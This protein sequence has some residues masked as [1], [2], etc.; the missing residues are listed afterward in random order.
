MEPKYL[1]LEQIYCLC[2]IHATSLYKKRDT[3]QLSA[4]RSNSESGQSKRISRSRVGMCQ[5]QN[6]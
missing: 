4:T 2:K 3:Q 5:K 1:N 6:L